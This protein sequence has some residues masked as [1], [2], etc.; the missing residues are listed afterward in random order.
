MLAIFV[1]HHLPAVGVFKKFR[2]KGDG[3]VMIYFDN[4]ATTNVSKEVLDAMLPYFT[5]IYGNPSSVYTISNAPQAALDDARKKIAACFSCDSREIFFTASGS[6]ADNWAIKG[7]MDA[8]AKTGKNKIITSAI[9]HHAVL[10]TCEYM[11]KRGYDVTYLPVDEYGLV[12]PEALEKAIDD[13]TAIVSVMF[14]NNEIGTIQ[15]IKELAAI[16]HKHNALFHTDAVQA[17]GAVKINVKDLDVDLLSISAHK[18]HGPKGVGM[19]YIKKG[20]RI[21]SFIHGGMQERGKRAGTDKGTIC[22]PKSRTD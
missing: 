12:S 2:Q 15:P 7:V 10:T 16:A 9:E 5:D 3:T 21:S 4:A 18:C 11:E 13:K 6:E 8:N 22:R 20:T 19:L 17:A 14:A 1:V